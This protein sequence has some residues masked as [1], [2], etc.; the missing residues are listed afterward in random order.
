MPPRLDPGKVVKLDGDH[1]RVKD[2]DVKENE[3]KKK[4]TYFYTKQEIEEMEQ[5][6][7]K[8]LV[9]GV[10]DFNKIKSPS[11][12]HNRHLSQ[13]NENIMNSISPHKNKDNTYTKSLVKP[14]YSGQFD[15]SAVQFS[16]V[17]NPGKKSKN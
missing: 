15:Q 17:Q 14:K 8:T 12:L 9:N 1:N 6:K 13:Q 4:F 2:Y 10:P 16:Y 5:R 7:N 3:Q 11:G